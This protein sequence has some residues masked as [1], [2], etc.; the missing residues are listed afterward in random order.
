MCTLV[1]T[2]ICRSVAF[3]AAAT[4]GL[5]IGALGAPGPLAAQTGMP[6]TPHATERR[7]IDSLVADAVAAHRLASVAVAVVQGHD[8]IVVRASGLADPLVTKRSTTTATVYRLG[9]V[10]KQFT[11]AI[12]LQLAQ[13]GR[14]SLTDTVGRYLPWVPA[15]WRGVTI[16]QLLNHTSGLPSYTNIGVAW[17]SRMTETLSPDTL[18]ALAFSAPPDFAPGT[19][20]KYNNGGYV[21]LGRIIELADHRTYA[22]SV[23]K[24]LAE[25]L[26]LR[27]LRYCTDDSN[28]RENAVG[29]Q[30]AAR[31][32]F[33]PSAPLSLSQPF[34]AGA[35]CA[36]V[37]DVVRWNRALHGG[38]VLNAASYSRMIT[39]EGAARSSHYGFGIGRDSVAGRLRL[40]H[41]GAV[42]G[43][44]SSNAF[45]PDSA[46]T[47]AVLSNT[48]GNDVDALA[49][50][51]ERVLLHQPL[52]Q[53][54]VPIALSTAQLDQHVG[55][56]E[57]ALPGRSLGLRVKRDGTTLIATFDGDTPNEL[58]P[59]GPHRFML[60]EDESLQFE[61]QFV[62]DSLTSLVLHSG[63]QTF[64]GRRVSG[65][66]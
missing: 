5:A 38:R 57:I 15:N 63:P 12:V 39:P 52:Q 30:R 33:Q 51:I 59:I 42:N 10:T 24:R 28:V 27:S 56:F 53:R 22:A 37:L 58:A 8:T 25:P 19:H 61:F 64:T 45:W 14:L 26:G 2:P 55:R 34:S 46:L 31:G 48:D 20:W 50:Q 16:A 13:E 36:N 62:N 21:M 17:R 66:P 4:V 32:A 44:S 23:L 3:I 40:L 43:F 1:M 7:V 47:V 29:S 11:A 49:A 54:P 60:R 35:L 65:T 6:A 9:S 41:S 18:I